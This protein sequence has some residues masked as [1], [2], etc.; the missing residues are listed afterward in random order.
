[1]I[2]FIKSLYVSLR[3][4]LILLGF[5]AMFVAAY[6]SPIFFVFLKFVFIGFLLL[7]LFDII[8]LYRNKNGITATRLLPEKFSNG[9][10]N[11]VHISFKNLYAFPL[12]INIID[13]IPH[14]FQIRDFHFCIKLKSGEEKSYVYNIRPTER[15]VYQFGKLN[16]Y[17]ETVLGLARRRYIFAE[18]KDIAV[19]PS[20][21]QLHKYDFL[22][23]HSHLTDY[24][25]KKIRRL[26]QTMEF[27]QIK[28]YVSG[29][30]IR[31][32]NWKATA[33]RGK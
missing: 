12:K 23:I 22:A 7:F 10:K 3:L 24:G 1:M 19:Y 32:I 20:F 6:F 17:A 5:A 33:K 4:F 13:E 15:G 27:E 31:N 25:V 26:G 30:D 21:L 9:D 16:V 18:G 11:P 28:D 29:D 8:L 14:Q 2:K